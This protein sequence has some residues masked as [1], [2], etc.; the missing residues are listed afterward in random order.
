MDKFE[1]FDSFSKT[2]SC[3]TIVFFSDETFSFLVFIGSTQAAFGLI[4]VNLVLI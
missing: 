2:S 3:A 1:S 4:G